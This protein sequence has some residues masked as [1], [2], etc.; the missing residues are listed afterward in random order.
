VVLR[1]NDGGRSESK[2]LSS[3]KLLEESREIVAR[4]REALAVMPQSEG[5]EVKQQTSPRRK[6]MTSVN[7][8]VT[9]EQAANLYLSGKTMG[10]VSTE[11]GIS[12]NLTRKLIKANGTA[13]RT[14]SDRLKGRPR[15]SK[16][17]TP[18]A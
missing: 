5:N 4:A 13:T 16:T 6:A 3:Q 2:I 12:Y 17:S 10:E 8:A 9:P 11:L 14:H 1:T 18:Q 7:P 15:K